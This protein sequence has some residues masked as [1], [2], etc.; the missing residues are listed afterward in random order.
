MSAADLEREPPVLRAI[1]GTY[2]TCPSAGGASGQSQPWPELLAAGV[3]T[4]IGIDTH[5]N[6]YA[7]NLKLAVIKGRDRHD[8]LAGSSGVPMQRPSV[9][10]AVAAATVNGARGLGRDDLGR[11]VAG[12]KADLTAIDVGGLLVGSAAAPPEPLHNL[13][14]AHGLSVRYTMTAG[15]FQVWQGQVQV[16]DMNRLRRRAAVLHQELWARLDGEGWFA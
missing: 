5:S 13:L 12:A 10:D 14:Y 8:L 2:A 11:I 9:W 4:S 7:E 1:G 15:R 6:D 3:N 16:D